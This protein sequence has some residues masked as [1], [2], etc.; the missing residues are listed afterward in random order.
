MIKRKELIVIILLLLVI[1]SFRFLPIK[2][3]ISLEIFFAQK[4]YLQGL[5]QSHYLISV[6]VFICAYIL[7]VALAIPG[8]AALTMVSG[9]LFGIFPA[10]LY[11]NI[12][13][14]LGSLITF[15]AARFYLGG[16]VQRKYA[17]ELKIFNAEFER[18]G[19]VYLLLVRLQPFLH[20]FVENA[21]A[22]L[23]RVNIVTFIWTTMV[24]VFPGT[25]FMILLGA[26]IVRIL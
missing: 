5:V 18:R 25:L 7:F 19:V 8:V 22:G 1:L 10:L 3:W 24:G 21:L 9:V 17:K 2:N 12:G 26:Q 16:W 13:A 15:L 11:V 4:E 6:F 23:T 20:I 14:T